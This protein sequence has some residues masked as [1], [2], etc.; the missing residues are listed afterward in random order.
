MNP[1]EDWV[2]SLNES[3]W[4]IALALTGGGS[5]AISDFLRQ[6]GG[7]A[8]ILEA[9]VPYARRALTDFLGQDR[10]AACSVGTARA[11]AERA[12]ERATR[13]ARGKENVAGVGC[14]A[15]LVTAVPKHGPHRIHVAL[16]TDNELNVR[17]LVLNK[18][19]RTRDQEERIAADLILQSLA[20]LTDR[21]I[22]VALLPGE[23]IE[24]DQQQV[25]DTGSH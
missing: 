13:I 17:T 1:H 2:S 21:E 10:E 22:V 14:T 18:G 24:I 7:S 25:G 4:Q 15:S 5:L 8:T 19:E 9:T 11:M 12:Y 20:A 6:P 3:P 16:R 23:S